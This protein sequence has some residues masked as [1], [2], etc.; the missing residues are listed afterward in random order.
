MISPLLPQMRRLTA[1]T[2]V[3]C[4]CPLSV[5]AQDGSV[6]SGAR[7]SEEQAVQLALARHPSVQAWA[8][9]THAASAQLATAESIPAP[10]LKLGT[11]G[12]ASDASEAKRKRSIGVEWSPPAPGESR[13]REGLLSLRRDEAA[14]QENQARDRLATDVRLTHSALRAQESMLDEVHHSARLWEQVRRIG[15]EQV[16]AHRRTRAEWAALQIEAAAAQTEAQQIQLERDQTAARLQSLLALAG[17]APVVGRESLQEASGLTEVEGKAAVA[18]ALRSRPELGAIATRCSG[19]DLEDDLARRR[20]RPWLK[21]VELTYSAGPN[22]Q[23]PT[24]GVQVSIPL[25]LG[26][27]AYGS[28]AVS[29]ARRAGCNAEQDTLAR[30]IR[31][32]VAQAQRQLDATRSAWKD[33]QRTVLPLHDEAVE[34]AREAF[35]AR[36]LDASELAALELR[37]SRA[38]VAALRQLLAMRQAEIELARVTGRV[39]PSP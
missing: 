38:R 16:R 6:P 2:L 27:S 8:H 30:Q 11:Q 24:W 36:R 7:L 23:D 17:P 37:R 21:D 3:A 22:R 28:T 25:P 26:A 33:T 31:D 35:E 15:Q 14:H 34:G 4:A 13:L 19:A 9:R 29:E 5:H 20:E 32:E 39:T 10:L 12:P 18:A 1:L